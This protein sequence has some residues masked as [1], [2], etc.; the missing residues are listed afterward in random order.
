M[1]HVDECES[2]NDLMREQAHQESDA[3]PSAYSGE[4]EPLLVGCT[5]YQTKGR[6]QGTNTWESER[7]KNLLFTIMCR[8]VWVPVAGQ[9]VISEAVALAVRDALA[10]YA[11]GFTIK[12]PNDIYWN[13]RK[14]CG[15]L[16][17]NTLG[18]RHI[19]Y[20]LAGIGVNVNQDEFHSDA[21]NPVSLKQILGKDTDR[22][23][24][25]D[26]IVNRVSNNLNMLRNCE[27]ASIGSL[28]TS[29]LYRVHGFYPYRDNEG[30]FEAAI[31][32][33]EDDGHL[34][35]RDKE[36]NMRRYAFKEIEFVLPKS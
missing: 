7:G 34:V 24:L 27:Y 35:L 15:M 33:V 6:G 19:K 14:I 13:D 8:P 29:W 22:Q 28:Y 30:T 16:L 1:I 5:E 2:T 36:D 20:C 31:V 18:N 23:V 4:T 32:E 26:N 12:W 10:T 9:F 3:E 11:D 25:L 21:P 17:E